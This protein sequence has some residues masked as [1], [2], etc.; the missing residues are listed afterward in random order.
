MFARILISLLVA[1]PAMLFAANTP[2]LNY[3]DEWQYRK[4]TT[5]PQANWKTVDV[6]SL[7]A[8]WLSGNG[9][10]G[11]AGN[12]T[13]TTLIG[14][15]LS[16]MPNLYRNFY[17]RQNFG[18]PPV[19][20][21]NDHLLLTVDWDD[22]FIAWL[23]GIY[24]TNFN[25][26]NP[27][28]EPAAN[29]AAS[30]SHESSRGDNNPQPLRTFDL[31]P[32]GNRLGPGV[33]VLAAM[34]LNDSIGSSDCILIMDLDLG[35]PPT[36]PPGTIT[37]NTTWTAANSPY[38]I[39]NTITV[40]GG[41]T[42]T[43]E[44]G[45]RVLFNQGTGFIVN[46][47]L[48]AEG[49]AGSRITFTRNAGATSWARIDFTANANESRIVNADFS[50]AISD[51][52]IRATGTR[53]YLD[54]LTFSDTDAQLVDVVNTSII[55]RNSI[56]PGIGSAETIHF[57]TFPANGYALLE[58][59]TFGAPIGYND[60]IDFTGGNRPGPIVQF[61]NNTFLAAVDDCFDMDGTDAHIEGNVFLNVKQDSA[62]DS[63]S[64][65]IS[66]GADGGNTS[67]LV[68]VRNLFYNCDHSL[69]LKDNGSA[70]YQNNTVVSITP[71]PVAPLPSALI[72]F[73]EPHRGVPGGRGALLDGN[74]AW[75]LNGQPF[76]N[77][78]NS[79][80]FLVVNRSIIQ[81]TNHPGTGN[82]SADPM[83]VNWQTEL[84]AQN[85]RSNL[86][87]LPGSPAIGTGP[88]GL[89][90]GALV[91]AG[92]SISGEP[93]SPTTN[94][95]ATLP[96]AGPGI[97]AYRWK[98]DDGPWSVEVPLTN[99]FQISPTIFNNAQP[100]T[101]TGLSGGSHTVYV[102]GKNSAGSWQSTNSPTIS[103]TWV[104]DT[105]GDSD[106]DGMPDVWE[107]LYDLNR[108]DPAD[109]DDDPDGDGASNLAEYISGTDPRQS[110]S[111]LK[112]TSSSSSGE[113]YTIVFNAVAGQ[114][115]TVQYRNSLSSGGWQT[116][117][118]VPAPAVNGS[119]QVQDTNAGQSSA[120]Y[121]RLLTPAE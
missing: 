58:G 69:L 118:N 22:G 24:L 12:S 37:T 2:L 85:I 16:D 116:L 64:N 15:A 47:Q 52:N 110:A 25:T 27:P 84:T 108:E 120:R 77:F 121:Y 102:V 33:H 112:I 96:V 13:E 75:D 43:I 62:R 83:F 65:A 20:D 41:A 61:I 111:V 94:T 101:L 49:T 7:D 28:S 10:F 55:L 78:T 71:N 70:I 109:T 14:T 45:V 56:F 1:L 50:F 34:G 3:N 29:T 88:N 36:A 18:A 100:I 17:I 53:L 92:A 90:M 68:I 107:D 54:G 73:G 114:T 79:L 98:L 72:N 42:L 60:V 59:N 66:T 38:V 23:D 80:M 63:T 74:I 48:L 19:V 82:S 46:G 103:K 97:Y 21:T 44:P 95:S 5:A 51:G 113:A 115:Y 32:V 87:L 89:D 117:T 57:S 91:P 11:Y 106:N 105:G 35:P 76:I 26:A 39:S 40:A 9:G 81:G 86:A 104:V 99:S 119:L 93:A 8:T 6:G 4:G 67:E 30:A 31:G